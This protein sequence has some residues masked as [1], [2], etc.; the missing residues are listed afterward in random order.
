MADK[1]LVLLGAAIKTP[2]MSEAARREAGY[3]L[4]CLQKG[5]QLAMPESRP[6]PSVGKRCHELRIDDG[7][8]TWRIIHRVDPKAILIVNIFKKK[9]RT[10]PKHVLRESKERL[11]R[12]NCLGIDSSEK[13][14][15]QE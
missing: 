2:P 9:T 8:V 4:H 15:S 7:V 5:D 6:M 10:T 11:S 13:G 3:L 14:K 1:P 12:F